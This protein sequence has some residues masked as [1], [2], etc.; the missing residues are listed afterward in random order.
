MIVYKTNEY[1]ETSFTDSI[2]D[3]LQTTVSACKLIMNH[4]DGRLWRIV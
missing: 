2:V 4:S 3:D 1:V